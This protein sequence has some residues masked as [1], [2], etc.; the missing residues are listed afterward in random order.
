MKA[1]QYIGFFSRIKKQTHIPF[2]YHTDADTWILHYIF[3]ETSDANR[4]SIIYLL[5]KILLE[6][7][8]IQRDRFYNLYTIIHQRFS[9]FSMPKNIVNDNDTINPNLQ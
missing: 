9:N 3:I 5:K 7:N 6:V 8:L 1:D 2:T 4:L